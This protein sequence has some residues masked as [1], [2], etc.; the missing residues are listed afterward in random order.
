MVGFD[1]IFGGVF[2]IL[3]GIV[4]QYKA[5]GLAAWYTRMPWYKW[6]KD[7]CGYDENWARSSYIIGGRLFIALGVLAVLWFIPIN[8]HVVH[9]PK[10]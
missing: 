7:W 1:L 6:N 3:I 4:V 10:Y 9:W 2:V 5:D 8:L